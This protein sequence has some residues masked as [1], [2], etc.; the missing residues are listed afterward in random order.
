MNK[1]QKQIIYFGKIVSYELYM[2]DVQDNYRYLIINNK[3][4][5]EWVLPDYDPILK[6]RH[7]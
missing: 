2:K 3:G 5:K 6:I 4:E 1:K 7:R